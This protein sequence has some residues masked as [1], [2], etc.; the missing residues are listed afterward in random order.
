MKLIFIFFFAL[1]VASTTKA[2]YVQI[3]GPGNVLKFEFTQTDQ[4]CELNWI[5]MDLGNL[6]GI[7][8][9][10]S[11]AGTNTNPTLLT[12]FGTHSN[13]IP[14]SVTGFVNTDPI[15]FSGVHTFIAQFYFGELDPTLFPDVPENETGLSGG[16]KVLSTTYT[17]NTI[18]DSGSTGMMLFAA[19][20]LVGAAAR[21]IGKDIKHGTK[22]GVEGS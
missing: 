20:T 3:N 17:V 22:S 6:T 19:L 18:P 15:F 21:L 16:V 14:G 13:V 9:F 11:L 5:L 4:Q 2:D 8:L 7:A 10:D 1:V 12:R